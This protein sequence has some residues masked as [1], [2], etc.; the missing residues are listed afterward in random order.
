MSCFFQI[1]YSFNSTEVSILNPKSSWLQVQ[2][3]PIHLALTFDHNVDEK[4]GQI[5]RL[6]GIAAKTQMPVTGTKT[7]DR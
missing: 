4:S 6:A 2:Q 7:G 5:Q 1:N 3:N